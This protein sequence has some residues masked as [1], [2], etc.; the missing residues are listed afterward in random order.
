MMGGLGPKDLTY[1]ILHQ[2]RRFIGYDHGATLIAK[3][4]ETAGRVVVRQ[5]AWTKG[6]STLVGTEV[7]FVW[8]RLPDGFPTIVTSSD[9]TPVWETLVA[10]REDA[11]PPKRSILAASLERAGETVGCVEVSSKKSDFFLDKDTEVLRRFTAYLSW[12][13]NH[14]HTNPGGQH[15]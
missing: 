11:S 3:A 14:L 12:C 5:V 9:P 1:R 10:I 6:K 4:D 15:E 2:L 7:P 13:L 8:N